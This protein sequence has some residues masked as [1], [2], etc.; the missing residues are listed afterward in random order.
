MTT[1]TV[2]ERYTDIVQM[3]GRQNV[4]LSELQ[5]EVNTLIEDISELTGIQDM[6]RVMMYGEME[7]ERC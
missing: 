6:L 5:S 4:K 1:K 2:T 7:E 3:I